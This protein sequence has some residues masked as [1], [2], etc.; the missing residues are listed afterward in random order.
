MRARQE[1]RTADNTITADALEGILEHQDYLCALCGEI[2]PGLPSF[3]HIVP[4]TRGGIHSIFNL[5]MTCWPCN[6]KKRDTLPPFVSHNRTL[7]DDRWKPHPLESIFALW[8]AHDISSRWQ[9]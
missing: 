1:T 8:P 6:A 5:Q 7:L 4:I 2:P 9:D 3:D